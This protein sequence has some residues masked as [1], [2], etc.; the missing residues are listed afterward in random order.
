LPPIDLQLT[1][2]A[3]ELLPQWALKAFAFNSEPMRELRR[4]K[5]A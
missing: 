5:G 3:I 4:R 2:E 1:L